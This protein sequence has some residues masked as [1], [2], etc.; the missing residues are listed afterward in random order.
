LLA[1]LRT[2]ARWPPRQGPGGRPKGGRFAQVRTFRLA[3][4]RRRDGSRS[5]GPRSAAPDAHV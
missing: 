3:G 5:G 1:L 2:A 4:P